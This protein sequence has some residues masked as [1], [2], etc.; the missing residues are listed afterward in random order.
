MIL[1]H[2]YGNGKFEF[3][4]PNGDVWLCNFEYMDYESRF[5]MVNRL[6]LKMVYVG[7]YGGLTWSWTWSG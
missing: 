7:S 1:G 2:V 6:K 3:G 5:K 4:L